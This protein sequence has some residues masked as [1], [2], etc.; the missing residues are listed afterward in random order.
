MRTLEYLQGSRRKKGFTMIEL[1]VVVAIIAVLLAVILPGISTN[2]EKKNAA[3]L[4]A[5]DFYSAVQHTF[6]KYMKYEGDLNSGMKS[7]K[8]DTD[9]L[10]YYVKELNGNFPK[11]DYT[12][13][14]MYTEGGEARYIHAAATLSELLGF[15]DDKELTDTEKQLLN[16]IPALLDADEDG[17]YFAL[18]KYTDK[19]TVFSQQVPT[20]KVH[21]AY[22]LR[23][24]L[25]NSTADADLTFSEDR[26]LKNGEICG[27]CSSV[28]DSVKDALLGQKGTRFTN[29]EEWK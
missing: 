12:Y 28:K 23:N 5:M 9:E 21:S 15:A 29:K 18:V 7:A 2:K 8:D 24:D 16:D 10:I 14:E 1:I 22:Y 27:V 19:T 3:D 20:I 25:P 17:H 11:N 26:R 13:V 4:R 6:T